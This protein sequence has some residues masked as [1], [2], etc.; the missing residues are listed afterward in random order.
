M[1]RPLAH[2]TVLALSNTKAAFGL[3]ITVALITVLVAPRASTQAGLQQGP[4]GSIR[5]IT[6]DYRVS[7]EP[8]DF[9]ISASRISLAPIA[10]GATMA[11]VFSDYSTVDSD[12]VFTVRTSTL[13]SSGSTLAFAFRDG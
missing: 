6:A 11:T 7:S 1:L 4:T 10:G 2:R 5:M 8:P 9:T 12:M 3:V 13:P